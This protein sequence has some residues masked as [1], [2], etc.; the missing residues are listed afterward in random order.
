MLDLRAEAGR[1][2]QPQ[3]ARAAEVQAQEVIEADEVIHVGVRDEDVRQP[4]DP[5]RAQRGQVAEIEE[6]R[7]PL[8]HE[9]HVHPGSP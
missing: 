7:A 2:V 8:E 9:L 1:A 5:A 4:Q 6:Q 3:V